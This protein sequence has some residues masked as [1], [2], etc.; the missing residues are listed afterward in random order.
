MK[1][2]SIDLPK[3]LKCRAY[4]TRR[5]TGREGLRRASASSNSSIA[6]VKDSLAAAEANALAVAALVD[7]A[8]AADAGDANNRWMTNL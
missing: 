4:N 7:A 3:V 8:V 6:A 2:A 5:K 1:A